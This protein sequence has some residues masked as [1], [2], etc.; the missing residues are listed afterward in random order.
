MSHDAG[1][2]VE[3]LAKCVDTVT[4]LA[5]DPPPVP[6]SSEDAMPY[7]V[8]S[9]RGNIRLVSLGPKGTW[10]QYRSRAK[11]VR[12]VV[13][14]ASADWDVL[15]LRLVNRRAHLVWKANRCPRV[16]TQVGGSMLEFR[17]H[18]P[19][20]FIRRLV[21]L[22]MARWEEAN[23]RT[24]IRG[25]DLTFV[26][27]EDLKALYS[28]VSKHVFVLRES[29]LRSSELVRVP[30]RLVAAET[31]FLVAGQINRSK[32]VDEAVRAFARIRGGDLPHASLD[33]VGDGEA[34]ADLRAL[35]R[36]LDLGD[37]VRFHGWIDDR[38]A[39]L[40]LYRRS[41]VLLCLSHVDFLPRVVWE[42]MGSS[43]LVIATPVGAL[44]HAFRHEED[45]LFVPVGRV[46]EVE[47]AIGTLLRRPEL[48]RHILERGLGRAREATI[49]GLVAGML[50]KIVHRWPELDD[51]PQRSED[52]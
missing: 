16:V 37:A 33:V 13:A 4:L 23:Q 48:R 34:L 39:L 21:A 28:G 25:A 35:V 12:R 36:D 32:G 43:V 27:G 31:R 3:V 2:V 22:S 41:D 38:H 17:R 19:S 40:E 8:S 20:P 30:D 7:A 45:L 42:S 5:Y 11:R 51:G 6:R 10:R 49:E 52:G 46:A 18:A 47:S 29:G 1:R 50:D 26:V 44:P 15:L 24:I 9:A 14:G